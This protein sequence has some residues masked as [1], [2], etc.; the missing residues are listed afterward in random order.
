MSRVLLIEK[1]RPHID[2][3][4]AAVFGRLEYIFGTDD[5]RSSV[6]ST[7]EFISDLLE[8]MGAMDFD[9]ESDVLCITGSMVP[10]VI[11][12]AAIVHHY[13]FLTVLLYNARE[14]A[15]VKRTLDPDTWM[16]GHTD[17]EEN[18]A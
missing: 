8:R 11:A 10:T 4:T 14:D 5:R 17:V 16:K 15:Y 2:T 1:P 13:G 7:N 6:F 9:H 12:A 3:S 18:A